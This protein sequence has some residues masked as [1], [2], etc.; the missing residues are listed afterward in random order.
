MTQATIQIIDLPIV[1]SHSNPLSAL[2]EMVRHGRAAV[3][4]AKDQGHAVLTAQAALQAHRAASRDLRILANLDLPESLPD[5][6][7]VVS[8]RGWPGSH[9]LNPDLLGRVLEDSGTVSALIGI[10]SGKRGW[11]LT[12]HD[13]L[14]HELTRALVICT[15]P[16]DPENDVFHSD[17]VDADGTCPN[18]QG[19]R[20]NCR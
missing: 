18:H 8:P 4:V 2:H 9:Q 17:E 7:G 13:D 15:C 19:V 6:V 11:V 5:M 1:E 20:L 10:E 16:V 12:A 14:A 3:L